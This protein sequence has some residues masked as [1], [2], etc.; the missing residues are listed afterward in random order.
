MKGRFDLNNNTR[1]F[2]LTGLTIIL[3]ITGGMTVLKYLQPTQEQKE[4]PVYSFESTAGIDYQVFFSPNNFFPQQSAG[5]GQAYITPLTEYVEAHFNYLLTSDEPADIQG[6]Y[7]A[8]ALLTGY[9]EKKQGEERIKVKAWEINNNVVPAT[10]FSGQ[11]DRL[12]L[13]TAAPINIRHYTNFAETVA[14]EWGY[15]VNGFIAGLGLGGLALALAAQNALANLFGGLIIILEKPFSIGDWIATPSVEGTVETITF[16]STLIRGFDQAVI[17]VPN[18]TLANEPITN[19]TRMG[20]RRI[21]YY[22]GLSYATT[23]QEM[24]TCVKRIRQMLNDHPDIHK[25]TIM[26]NF[27]SFGHDSHC[28]DYGDFYLT[29]NGYREFTHRMKEFAAN[30]PLLFVLSGGSNPQVAASAIP[31]VIESLLD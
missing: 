16:R 25:E 13:S 19:H 1:R 7:S 8:T 17:T 18:A 5:P 14:N 30:R 21:F 20:K 9:V 3:L 4:V 11:Q 15:D 27:E 28:E 31:T 23:G 22:L 6:Q 29:I 2:L 12:E 10:P 26:V 24:E